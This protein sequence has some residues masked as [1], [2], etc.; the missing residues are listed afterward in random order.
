MQPGQIVN[1]I[2]FVMFHVILAYIWINIVAYGNIVYAPFLPLHDSFVLG[3]IKNDS[4]KSVVT[5]LSL[6]DACI[7][8]YIRSCV[9]WQDLCVQWQQ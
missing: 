5:R 4:E 1:C 6:H 8:S 2:T 7:W 3:G 9:C